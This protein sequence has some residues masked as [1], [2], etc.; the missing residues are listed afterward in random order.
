MN[1]KMDSSQ[2]AL[3]SVLD[4]SS[5]DFES[6]IPSLLEVLT[7]KGQQITA[8]LPVE[9]LLSDICYRLEALQQ[10]FLSY[11]SCAQENSSLSQR[12]EHKVTN[13]KIEEYTLQ[14]VKNVVLPL[15]HQL[16]FLHNCEKDK[17]PSLLTPLC[18]LLATCMNLADLSTQVLIWNFCLN[19]LLKHSSYP[20]RGIDNATVGNNASVKS[21]DGVDLHSLV[22]IL[23]CLLREYNNLKALESCNLSPADLQVTFPGNTWS[24]KIFQQTIKLITNKNDKIVTKVVSLVVVKLLRCDPDK[25][26]YRLQILWEMVCEDFRRSVVLPS[27]GVGGSSSVSEKPYIVLCGLADFYFP[28]SKTSES[29]HKQMNLVNNKE[30]WAMIQSGL[31]QKN[32]V[33][34]KRSLYL[35]KRI[36]DICENESET[37]IPAENSIEN[38]SENSLDKEHAASGMANSSDSGVVFLW[39]PELKTQLSKV[40]EN[41][42]LLIETLNEKQVRTKVMPHHSLLF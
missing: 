30:F 19:A 18:D 33:T 42:I 24:E 29:L 25:L 22:E 11:S 32:P 9:S 36:I 21:G 5:V 35:L 15:L 1:M 37:K 7:N 23:R 17:A 2:K 13:C 34:R 10:V 31:V 12:Q 16:H 20:E 38:H 6:L 3:C 39:N 14:C 8:D 40:W 27:S 28:V 4:A 26:H 41:F